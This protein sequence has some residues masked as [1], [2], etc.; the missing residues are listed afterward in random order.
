[1]I[2][3]FPS[4][5]NVGYIQYHTPI[6]AKKIEFFAILIPHF[7]LYITFLACHLA[8]QTET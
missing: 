8:N 6:L 7:R 5:S 4:T 2:Q 1:M 3:S